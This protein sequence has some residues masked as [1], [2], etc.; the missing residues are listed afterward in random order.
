MDLLEKQRIENQLRQLTDSYADTFK[1]TTYRKKNTFTGI[2]KFTP[3]FLNYLP[4]DVRSVV[5]EL[6]ELLNKS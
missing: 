4:F 1:G 3:E 2:E 6:E 5:V